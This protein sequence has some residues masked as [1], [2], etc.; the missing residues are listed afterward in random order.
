MR[1]MRAEKFS[2]YEGLK[3]V[4]LP[5]PAVSEGKVL[6]RM[7]AAGVTPLDHTILSGQ[8]PL[9]TKGPPL[10]LGNEGAGVV[11]EGGGTDFPVGSRVMFTGPYGV[12]EDG[13]YS[14]WLAVRKESLCLIPEAV[15]DVSAAGIPVAYLTAQMALTLAGFQAGKTVLAPAIG[16]SVGNAVTQLARALGA[17]HAIS[18]TT[19]HMKAEQ[20]KALGFNE[21]ID[22][23]FEK[24][25]HGVSR[26]T[27]G[28]GA[29]IV[30]DGVAG[31]VLNEA[32]G[33]LALDGSLTTLGIAAGRKA[34]IDVTN[35]IVKRAS[36]K[37]FMLFVQPLV[38]WADAWNAIVPLLQSGANK[39]IDAK[40]YPLAEAADALRYLIE[41]RPF[42]RVVLTI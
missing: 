8:F 37:S 18:S 12:F 25:G 3:L 21:V 14:E 15:D 41:G 16:G 6:L 28:Y 4:D 20:A 39:P 35:L 17:K 10:V 34:T 26:I 19:N 27:G 11:E 23:S 42:G 7:T 9:A 2:G 5:K 31:E 1:A 36:I 40:T 22:T 33:A 32:L 24:L 38:A 30:I 29:D 13:A